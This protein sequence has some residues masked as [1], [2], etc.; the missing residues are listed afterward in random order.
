MANNDFVEVVSQ[1]AG[2]QVVDV[3]KEVA[4]LFKEQEKAID[5]QNRLNAAFAGAR[6]PSSS[7][8]NTRETNAL[9]AEQSKRIEELEK[10]IRRL[11]EARKSGNKQTSDEIVNGRILRQ[12]ADRQA[13]ANSTLAN[14]YQRL[15]AQQALAASRVQDIIARGRTA[16]QTQR[17]Y[18]RELRNAQSE[19]DRLNNRVLAA[20]RAVG[21]YN[22]KVGNYPLQAVRGLKDLITAFGIVGGATAFAA[23]TKD[24]FQTTKQLQSMNI[25]LAQV[26]EGTNTLGQSQSFLKRISDDYGLSLINITTQYTRFYSAAK[27]KLPLKDIQDIFESVG[28]AAGVL[29]LSVEQQE[30]AFRALEQMLSKG[31]IQA[32]EIRGQLGERLPGAFGILAKSMG[33]TEIQLNK[34]LKDGK[35]LAA[36][37]LP[38]FA[39]ELERAY[40]IENIDRVETL[41]AETN[42]LANA[43]TNFVGAITNGDSALTKFLGSALNGL[44]GALKGLDKFIGGANRVNEYNAESTRKRTLESELEIYQD[45]ADEVGKVAAAEKARENATF[46]AGEIARVNN[47][48]RALQASLK[49]T[50]EL[51]SKSRRWVNWRGLGGL[52]GLPSSTYKTYDKNQKTLATQ[53]D[54]V[55]ANVIELAK[56]N[57]AYD[58]ATQY[59]EKDTKA[60]NYNTDAKKKKQKAEV[61][62][63]R[64]VYELRKQNTDNFI[65]S[66]NRIMQDEEVNYDRR[67][68]AANNY[69]F[70]KD[71]LLK[72][73]YEEEIR[74][75]DLN[76]KNQVKT[77]EDAIA[78]GQATNE[79]LAQLEYQHI[80]RKE[81]IN[82][83]YEGKK[84][85]LAIEAAKKLQGVLESIQDRAAKIRIT[86]E[87]IDGARQ[88]GLI[89]GNVNSSTTLKDFADIENK[90]REINK[91]EEDGE[92]EKYRIELRRI[93]AQ[94]DR[95]KLSNGVIENN[96]EYVKLTEEG[97][98]KEKKILDIE[99][100]RKQAV[101]EITKQMKEATNQYLQSFTDQPFADLGVGELSKM[102]DQVTYDVVNSLGG[103]ET[104][105]GSTFDKLID[106]AGTLKEKFA[107]AF[108]TITEIAQQA[109]NII[110]QQNEAKFNAQYTQL[111]REKELAL[112]FAADTEEAREEVQ[113]QYDERRREIRRK[114]L[115]AQKEQAIF[116]AVINTAQAV[117]AAL[118]TGPQ[119]IALAAIVGAL[120]AAQIALIASQQIPAYK[121][122]TD[123]HK[124]GLAIVG[125]GGKK[126][127]IWQ[128]SS[129]FSVSP[130]K[131][132]LVNLEKGSKVFPDLS[133]LDLIGGRLP[134][135][136]MGGSGMSKA[137]MID[138]LS[139]TIG[140]M[141]KADIRID[142]HGF[143]KRIVK[144][145][146]AQ[147]ILN[148]SATFRN[149][150]H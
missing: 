105:V 46:L 11:T 18:N 71:K 125:D 87:Q 82:A 1:Q 31:N 77:Y 20:D 142:E 70:Q 64:E 13:L 35:V 85:T 44:T 135:M 100:K 96:S 93:E 3:R 73:D 62:Y 28:K 78:N 57:G 126:E 6:V 16:E 40:S 8:G 128:P 59:V 76:Y 26:S 115:Q 10:N 25:A 143:T 133:K 69:Y 118:A 139:G 47:E 149:V 145:N 34:L 97:Y 53:R 24:I 19:F 136:V 29:G 86:K 112:S 88:I 56:L 21:R 98:E 66:E 130:D 74:L 138:A 131:D 121:M 117:V 120:G 52:I 95:L 104:R 42:R 45:I 67:L 101:A 65:E 147:K 60:T 79:N 81:K 99:N 72:L 15:A 75:N 111:E 36:D 39:R 41:T 110:Q 134:N 127:L 5:A 89:L 23:I 2:K 32:E 129:G 48:Q 122:G 33:V 108:T 94:K 83:D 27:D 144:G 12:N 38:E 58:A 61:D 17:Q 37:V 140:N 4:A 124:G 55:K 22:R 90:I 119:G 123:N 80:L 7:G 54:Q 84:S 137:D 63:L 114:E 132:T 9:L 109:F 30:G 51:V 91:E 106:Q 113:R 102:F 150:L 107:V 141:P 146:T 14:S 92:I 43:W 50:E 49:T 68:A 103:I 148:N 116:N